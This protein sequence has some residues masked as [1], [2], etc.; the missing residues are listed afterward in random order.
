MRVSE[1][2][3]YGKELPVVDG[4][5][6]MSTM[7]LHSIDTTIV[8]LVTDTGLVGWGEVAPLGPN[9]QPAH[10]LGARAVLAELAPSLVGVSARHPLLLYRHMDGRL[11]GHRYAKAAIDIAVADLLAK[12]HGIRVCELLGGAAAERVPAYYAI[13]IGDPDETV[14]RALAKIDEGYRRLQLKVGGRDVATDIA[15]V[16]TVWERIGHRVQLVVD[17]NRGL[18]AAD[19][20]RLSLACRDIP[21][22]LEQPCNTMDEVAAIRPQIVHPII[23]D[24]NLEDLGAVLRAISLG[25]CDGF[26]LKVSRVGGLSAMA[27]IRDVCAARSIPHTCEDSW[28]GDITA[29]A[30]VH[31]AATVEPRLLEGAW[32]AGVYIDEHYDPERGIEVRDGHFDVPTGPG[33]GVEPDE[34]RIGELVA[35]YG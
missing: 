16:R 19:A 6:T 8:K 22:A 14:A 32:T 31:V 35:S 33:L 1:I 29:A 26:G 7:T 2:H 24:E 9:Y 13:G 17:A 11:N 23:L 18:T 3:V 12:H 21:F 28:G 27:T 34:S 20:M 30:I 4:P 5:Y 10:A 25:L 15:V